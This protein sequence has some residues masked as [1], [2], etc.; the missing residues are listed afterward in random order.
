MEY[1]LPVSFTAVIEQV[2]GLDA[3]FL[4]NSLDCVHQGFRYFGP[5]GRLAEFQEVLEVFFGNDEQVSWRDGFY[6]LKG[7]NQII[8]IYDLTGDLVFG[9]CAENTII[10]VGSSY[11]FNVSMIS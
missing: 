5:L 3:L 1:G 4:T 10:H 2:E 8:F 9:D 6:V 11:L 7:Y